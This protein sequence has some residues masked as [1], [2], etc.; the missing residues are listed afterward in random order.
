MYS[1]KYSIIQPSS[2]KETLS[3]D[4]SQFEGFRQHDCQEFLALLLDSLHEELVVAGS[5]ARGAAYSMSECTSMELHTPH[6]TE[7][8]CNN[9]TANVFSFNSDKMF[10]KE[11][12]A[13]GDLEKEFES[14]SEVGRADLESVNIIYGTESRGSAIPSPTQVTAPWR[15]RCQV[16]SGW[17]RFMNASRTTGSLVSRAS[18]VSTKSEQETEG[19]E[20][21][22]V[23]NIIS[24]LV[25]NEQL[26][27]KTVV[28]SD[29]VNSM[30]SLGL[31]ETLIL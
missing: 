22:E 25:T 21:G 17:L 23:A 12:E 20:E 7:A 16:T 13:E 19:S 4:H 29:T 26:K 11:R 6:S 15:T 3:R 1:G 10:D 27:K 8:S 30:A 2:F 28:F 9:D 24:N 31:A 18:T 14:V 5:L